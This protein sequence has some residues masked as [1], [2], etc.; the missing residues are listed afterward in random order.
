MIIKPVFAGGNIGFLLAIVTTFLWV[1]SDIITKLQARNDSVKVQCFY[2]F[3]YMAL[4]QLPLA[5]LKWST[6]NAYDIIVV[7][8]LGVLQLANIYLLYKSFSVTEMVIVAPFDCC[9]L[10]FTLIF[11][12]GLYNEKL[13]ATSLIGA[14]IIISSLIY[15]SRIDAKELKIKEKTIS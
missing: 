12:Y 15:L 10:L 8:I 2:F 1:T 3:I 13:N 9:R 5:I 4:F 7:I 6:P 11:A 14:I